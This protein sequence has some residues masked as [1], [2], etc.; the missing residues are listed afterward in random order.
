MPPPRPQPE[1]EP[2]QPHDVWLLSG[3]PRRGDYAELLAGAADPALDEPHRSQ[4][5]RD[6]PRT[7]PQHP[8]FALERH[9]EPPV[10]DAA[11]GRLRVPWR[12]PEAAALTLVP[13]LVNVLMAAVAADPEAGYT[14]GMNYIAAALLLEHDECGCFDRLM[15]L[16]GLFPGFF[17]AADLRAVR[18]ESAVLDAVLGRTPVGQHME[19]Q[20]GSTRPH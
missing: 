10:P 17:R 6:V 15:H 7:F 8:A 2:E 13:S 4:V 12:V 19:R 5:Y 1:P 16:I 18:L 14:Q 9:V 20:L 11:T 3:A